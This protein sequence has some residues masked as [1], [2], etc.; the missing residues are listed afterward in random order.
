VNR[1]ASPSHILYVPMKRA[2]TLI[3]LLVVIAIIAILA[4][5][6]FPTFARAKSAAKSTQCVSNL[7][8]LSSAQIMYANDNEDVN[9][10]DEANIAGETKYWSDLIEPYVHE[11]Q[12]A[13]CPETSSLYRDSQPWTFSYAINNVR[14][15][16]GDLVGAAW[17][18]L[19]S[20]RR[21]SQIVLFVDGWPEA[22]KP[23]VNADREE[24]SWIAG[25]RNAATNPLVD[26][27]PRHNGNFNMAFCDGHAGKASRKKVD[28][29]WTS[30][31]PD[32]LWLARA[33]D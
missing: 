14:E 2:F 23:S 1:I 31:T 11:E 33:D 7:R 27:N 10:G 19:S 25:A 12:F 9:V 22:S 20:I 30:G 21:P 15:K 26:G 32:S 18:P 16:D 6:L 17:A 3:E 4:A 28:G 24:I 8:Q 5:L 13:R 29:R